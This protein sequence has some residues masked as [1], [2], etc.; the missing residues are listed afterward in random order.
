MINPVLKNEGKIGV[1]NWKFPLMVTVYIS[2]ISITVL[3]SFIN[4][5]SNAYFEGLKINESM[6]LY[7][8]IAVVQGILLL[9][10]VPSM[11]STSISSER[12]KQTLE[13]LISTTMSPFSIVVGKLLAS[14]SKVI[15]LLLLTLPVYAL[16]F[17]IGGV[18]LS[19]VIQLLV[20]FIIT[21]FFIGAIGVFFSTFLGSSKV[22]TMA[23]YVVVLLLFI[24]ILV[25]TIGIFLFNAKNTDEAIMVSKMVYLSPI[26]GLLSL[27]SNQLGIANLSGSSII[28]LMPILT[29]KGI[30]NA[31]FYSQGFMII[32]TILLVL[33]SSRRLNPLRKR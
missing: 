4:L 7:L 31:A 20:Y 30:E 33:I 18:A 26:T 5:T 6:K 2:V 22:S 3:Y 17:L 12:E 8:L 24:G 9:F 32:S 25:I 19:S 15:L 28:I 27:F 21:T 14:V 23:T 13:V 16:S 29:M 1:R 11:S 10:I